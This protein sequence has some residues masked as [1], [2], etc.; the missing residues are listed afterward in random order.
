[1]AR[2]VPVTVSFD[3]GLLERID[4]VAEERRV[5]RSRLVSGILEQW[6]APLKPSNET[7]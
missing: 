2:R 5:P 4:K 6:L 3:V 1:M 7:H